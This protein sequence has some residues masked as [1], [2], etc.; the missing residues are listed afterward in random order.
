MELDEDTKTL[1]DLR[2]IFSR[3]ELIPTRR[4]GFVNANMKF[5]HPANEATISISDFFTTN[6]AVTIKEFQQNGKIDEIIKYKFQATNKTK[7][8]H[9]LFF[10]LF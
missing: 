9:L 3:A 2:D 4:I 1:A 8:F 7:H 5:V 10:I 6:S